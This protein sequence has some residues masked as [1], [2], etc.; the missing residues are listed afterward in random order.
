MTVTDNLGDIDSISVAVT[1]QPGTSQNPT[2]NLQAAFTWSTDGL[3]LSV[4]CSSTKAT[5]KV[6]RCEWNFGEFGA[7]ETVG[8]TSTHVYKG[9]GNYVVTL[10]VTDETGNIDITSAAINVFEGA[11]RNGSTNGFDT[12][13]GGWKPS[14]NLLN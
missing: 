4:D 3:T 6:T 10:K 8:A 11:K 13:I 7:V 12:N 14:V 9:N 5:Y 1:V 2:V